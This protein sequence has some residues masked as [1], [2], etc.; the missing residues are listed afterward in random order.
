MPLRERSSASFPVIYERDGVNQTLT[1]RD[2]LKVAGAG[3][4]GVTLLGS[5]GC[6][7]FAQLPEEYL[8]RG[9]SRMN[10]VVVIIDS[11]R[12][13]HVGAYGSDRIKTPSL[14]ALAKESLRFT[15]AYPESMPSIPARRGIH[16]GIRTFPFRSWE[17]RNVNEDDVMLYGWEPIPEEQTTLAEILA[18]E[19]YYNLFVTDTLH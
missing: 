6:S 8:P 4:A 11:L 1:R 10:V 5:A 13:D 2:F 18:E 17:L 7:R 9:G 3:A 12:K 15:R 16:T 19:G 14:D